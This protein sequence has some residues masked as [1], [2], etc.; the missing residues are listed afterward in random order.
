MNTNI[1]HMKFWTKSFHVRI[2]YLICEN[3]PTSNMKM[4]QFYMWMFHF[5]CEINV[6]YT[7][8]SHL[9]F[10]TSSFYMWIRYF[11]CENVP[12]SCVKM[13][14]FYMWIVH[15]ISEMFLTPRFHIWNCEPVH[16]ICKL[17]ISYVKTFPLHVWKC[18]NSICESFISHVKCFLHQDFTY[19][20]L[21]Q[22]ILHVN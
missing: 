3:V 7:K 10:W 11:I 6:S 5:I 4:F 19:V 14:Q 9:K 13:F 15:F 16:F 21:N 17:D 12:T 22:F 18:F 1:S 2:R 20:I 8:I